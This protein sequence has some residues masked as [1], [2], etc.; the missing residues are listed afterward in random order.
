VK[1]RREIG[2]CGRSTVTMKREIGRCERSTV[3]MRK[4]F[5]RCVEMRLLDGRQ[6]KNP[7]DRTRKRIF[8]KRASSLRIAD[9]DPGEKVERPRRDARRGFIKLC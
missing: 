3:T 2:R 4:E 5:G 7:D 9:V 1:M 6:V 8:Q